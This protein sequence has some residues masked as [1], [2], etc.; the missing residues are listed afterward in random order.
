M[1]FLNKVLI[2]LAISGSVQ[3]H[4]LATPA[5][6]WVQNM[7][8]SM[9]N[10]S[11]RGNF[12]YRHEN[13]LESM[14]I[15]HVK[16]EHGEKERLLSL[17]GE[18]REIIRD[19]KNITCV[20]PSSRTVVVDYSKQNSF[21][22]LFIPDD[23]ASISKYYE[24]IM[25]GEGRI[26]GQ[27]SVVVHITPKDQYR[28]GLKLWINESN[29]LLM[30]SNLVGE[31][32]EILEEVMFTNLQL[33]T[34]EDDMN[35]DIMPKLEDDFTMVRYHRDD[36]S[37]TVDA[38]SMEWTTSEIPAGFRQESILKRKSSESEEFVHQMIFTDGLASLSIFIE[39]QSSEDHRGG[40]SM[41]AVNAYIRNLDEYSITVIGEVPAITVQQV[42]ESIVRN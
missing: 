41:G 14:S 19:N 10:L 33:L 18:A 27:K 29:G 37:E 31:N 30:K 26:A 21:S 8:E 16:D 20:W 22:P 3:T 4:S 25:A 15:F 7:S 6:D 12:V 36:K 5:M 35:I 40:T 9:R 34:E 39:K 42:A 38:Q 17:N 23:I 28:Y 11:Y 2:T 13:Q 32:D 24:M 1:N